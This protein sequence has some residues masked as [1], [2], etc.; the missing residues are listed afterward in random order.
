MFHT[1][2][3]T[4]LYTLGC[5][6]QDTCGPHAPALMC[7]PGTLL[8]SSCQEFLIIQFLYG[9][10]RSEGRGVTKTRTSKTQTSDPE[11]LKPP[12]CLENTDPQFNIFQMS[13]LSS[14]FNFQLTIYQSAKRGVA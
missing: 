11:K 6:T 3:V 1:D 9:L 13:I 5:L 7:V 12:G 8:L 10:A 4:W 14:T 2:T